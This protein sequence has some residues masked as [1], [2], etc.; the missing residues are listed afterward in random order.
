MIVKDAE[1]LVVGGGLAGCWAAL[2]AAKLGKKV[3]L[4]DKAKV[5]RSGASTF[6]AGVMLAPQA[7]DDLLAWQAEIVER[8]DYLNDQ[9][10][11]KFL[12]EDQIRRIE[13]LQR[14]GAPFEIDEGGKLARIKGR[15]HQV[16]RILMFHGK[17][18]MELMAR[19]VAHEEN[20][21]LCERTVV[22]DLLFEEAAGQKNIS[23]VLGFDARSGQ[24]CAFVAPVVIMA[25]GAMFCRTGGGMVDNLSGDG[26]AMAYESGAELMGMEFCTGGNI[27]NWMR[28]YEVAGINMIQGSGAKIVNALGERFML[29]YDPLL[30]E[31]SLKDILIRAYSKEVLEGRGPIY[32][33]MRHF[34][35]EAWERCK[36]V[37]P[38]TMLVFKE[39]GIDPAQTMIECTPNVKT[40]N[41]MG[42]QGG[43]R[44]DLNCRTTV[45]GLLAAGAVTKN[46]AHGTYSVGGVNLAYC[47]VSGYRAGE[48]AAE[49]VSGSIKPKFPAEQIES[50]KSRIEKL[51]DDET[52]DTPDDVMLRFRRLTTP[53]PYSLF[54]NRSRMEKVLVGIAELNQKKLKAPDPHELVKALEVKNVLLCARLKYKASLL[55]EECRGEHYREE[56][57]YRDDVNWLKWIKVRK[58]MEN[59]DFQFEEIPFEKYPVRLKEHVRIPA[60]VQY[61]CADES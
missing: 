54:P 15:G 20:V 16:A 52:G 8:G 13:D 41:S 2:R 26:V 36:R 59:D 53:A 18:L 39:A 55:R 23:G 31:R 49:I 57:P 27:T 25:T 43:V 11:V 21:Q 51:L 1:I 3:I 38:K 46:L 10:W 30:A 28:K 48:T 56:F 14:W 4:I 47:C 22:T 50:A 32:V 37:I 35:A 33:D 7:D 17:K 9:E 6:A 58:Y 12:L 44:V 61:V 19:L 34:S 60:P 40:P 5:G 42:G 29:R 24:W 45:N